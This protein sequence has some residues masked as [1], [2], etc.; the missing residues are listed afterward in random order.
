MPRPSSD[1]YRERYGKDSALHSL[2]RRDR[3][4]ADARL[5]SIALGLEPGRYF[6]YVS[7]MEPEN[8]ALEVRQAFEQRATRR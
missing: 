2:R 3:Q 6:L 1:Y 8:H 7:R 5:R 4:G